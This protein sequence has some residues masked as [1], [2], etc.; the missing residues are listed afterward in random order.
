MH[1]VETAKHGMC[2][3]IETLVA[4]KIKNQ[5]KSP[6]NQG[7]RMEAS[8]VLSITRML[9]LTVYFTCEKGRELLLKY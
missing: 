9:N 6:Y 5:P 7:P 8:N 2:L 3:E 4:M 1:I